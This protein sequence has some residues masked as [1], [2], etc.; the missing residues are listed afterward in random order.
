MPGRLHCV[1]D[2]PD[3][4]VVGADG[5]VHA[6][7]TEVIPTAGGF[8]LLSAALLGTPLCLGLGVGMGLGLLPPLCLPL[9]PE[10]VR[11]ELIRHVFLL[12]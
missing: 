3:V 2:L 1:G 5:K 12:L 11:G 8:E 7:G 6:L 4:V 10:G 9:F